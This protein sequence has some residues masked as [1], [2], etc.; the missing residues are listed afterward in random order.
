MSPVSAESAV[1]EGGRAW[2][3]TWA[4]FAANFVTFGVLFSFGV[5]LSPIADTFGTTLGPVSPLFSATVL[6]YY[7][8]GAVGGRLGDRYGAGVVV[9]VGAVSIGAALFAA[10]QAQALWQLYLV[11]PIVGVAVGCCYPPLIGAVGQRFERRRVMAIAIVL[12]GVGSGTWLMPV[13]AR[14]LIDARGWRGTFQVWAVATTVVILL[15]VVALGRRDAGGSTSDHEPLGAAVLAGSAPFRRLYLAVVLVSPGFYAPLAFLNDYAV[16]RDV[17]EGRAAWLV[18]IVGASTVA[19]RLV[20]GVLGQRFDGLRQYR[21][22]YW[23]MTA[24]LVLW[25]FAGSSYALMATVAALHGIGWAVWVTA[26]PLVLTTWF[27]ARDLGGVL[28]AFYTGLGLGSLLG[29]AVSG[30]V[31]DNWGYRPAIIIVV[32]GNLAAILVARGVASPDPG[33]GAGV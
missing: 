4:A 1:E 3:V 16:V 10:S 24:G 2:L 11:F 32:V 21:L 25:G 30:F 27:G 19:A 33:P 14:A 12:A 26:A 29:P 22:S 15:V 9:T 20:I 17:S 6:V 23:V 5:Y 8:A 7:L 28:G 31:I 13:V 18:G